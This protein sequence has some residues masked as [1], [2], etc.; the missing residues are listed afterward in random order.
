MSHSRRRRPQSIDRVLCG[1]DAHSLFDEIRRHAGALTPFRQLWQQL[2]PAPLH[3]HARPVLLRYY[4][5]TVWVDSPVW[6]HQLRHTQTSIL[7]R[8]RTAGLPRVD[9]LRIRLAPEDQIPRR[10][11]KNRPAPSE[12]VERLLH[13]TADSLCDDDLA[14]AVSRLGRALRKQR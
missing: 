9:A 3:Q 1:R 8:L 14:A 10:A 6:A 12:Q 7:A 13:S 2:L 11:G 4:T 5:L